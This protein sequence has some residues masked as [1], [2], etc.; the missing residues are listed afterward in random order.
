MKIWC[1]ALPCQ[2]FETY[3][4]VPAVFAIMSQKKHPIQRNSSITSTAVK[5]AKPNPLKHLIFVPLQHLSSDRP[6]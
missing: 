2:Q 4:A 3:K 1:N 6:K 5:K